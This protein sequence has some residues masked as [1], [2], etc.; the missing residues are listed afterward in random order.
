MIARACVAGPF[1]PSVFGIE[2]VDVHAVAEEILQVLK[3]QAEQQAFEAN[4]AKLR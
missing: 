4:K 3:E 1:H 2:G